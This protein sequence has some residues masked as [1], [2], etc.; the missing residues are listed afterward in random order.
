MILDTVFL[1]DLLKGNKDAV[2]KA[3]ELEKNNEP[4]S[5]TSVSV[6]EIW[7][8]LPAKPM[9]TQME[10]VLELFKSLNV[11]EL[12]FDAALEGGE[13]QRTLKIKGEIIDAEDAMIAGIARSQGEKVLTRNLKHFK[14]I[15]NI[16][17]ESY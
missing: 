7:Q 11:F 4:L 15:N 16:E 3:K 9:V 1:I 12:D 6:F 17:V 14:R 2:A 5:T 10:N 13:I 8:G